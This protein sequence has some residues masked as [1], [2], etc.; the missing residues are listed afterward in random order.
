MAMVLHELCT[1]AVKYGA[2]SKRSG[3]VELEWWVGPDAPG[4]TE[5]RMQWR[6]SG[7]PQVSEP[8]RRGFGTIMIEGALSEELR[9]HTELLF[10]PEGLVFRLEGQLPKQETAFS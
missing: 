10:S 8:E 3:H 6:E 4:D 2:L 1:N 5:F 9:G 7:G